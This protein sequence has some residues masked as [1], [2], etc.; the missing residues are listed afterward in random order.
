MRFKLAIAAVMLASLVGCGG[1]GGGSS[2]S[3]SNSASC[4]P[5]MAN[6]Q[7]CN[8]TLSLA[9]VNAAGR[10]T[11]Q[12]AHNDPGTLVVTLKTW[13]GKPVSGTLVTFDTSDDVTLEPSSGTAT[14]DAHGVARMGLPAGERGGSFVAGAAA[15]VAGSTLRS[16]VVYGV[17]LPT[18]SLSLVDKAGAPTSEVTPDNAGTLVAA[19]KYPNGAPVS[20]TIVTFGTNDEVTMVPASR[21]VLT[22]ARGEARV[23]LPAGNR[24][25]AF[26][27]QA[28]ADVRG[29]GLHQS[30]EYAVTFPVL[31]LSALAVQ[32]AT[33]SAGGNASLTVSV[34]RGGQPYT[35]PL[36]VSFTSPCVS[37]GK[38]TIGSPVTTQNG[39]ARA[40]YSDRGCGVA[41]T[42]TASAT[43]GEA[44][45]TAQ[46]TLN[47]LPAASGSLTFVSADTTNIALVGTGGAGRQ[48]F[49]TLRFRVFDTTGNPVSGKT[50]SFA[51]ANR[52]GAQTTT[53]GGLV[54]DPPSATS[55]PD[56][57]VTTLVKNGTIPTSVRVKAT[58]EVTPG[59]TI[60]TLSNV[61]VVSTG[62]PDQR[63][64]SLSTTTGNCEGWSVDQ[65]EC[66]IVTARLADHFGNPAP[67]GTAVNFTTEGGNIQAS[68]ITGTLLDSTTPQG[69]ST[70]SQQGPGSG[71]C[72]VKLRSANPRSGDGRVTVLAY[73]LGEEDFA[74]ANGNNR[75]DGCDDLSGP[76][77]QAKHDLKPDIYRDDDENLAYT[78]GEPCIRP[79]PAS[80][81]P[82]CN[83]P[84]DG[85]YS[86]VLRNPPQ[87]DAPLTVYVSQQLVQI[88]SGSE[89]NFEFL[90]NEFIC[91]VGGAMPVRFHARD[92]NGNPMPAGSTIRVS[93]VFGLITAPVVPTEI[94]VNNYVLSVGSPMPQPVYEFVVGCPTSLTGRL[95]VELTTPVSRTLTTATRP[96]NLP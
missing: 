76:E 72:S 66:S 4:T 56:G 81:N 3:G 11:T 84:G 7:A 95:I 86:G 78:A 23:G 82:L 22:D 9:L 75:C 52:D 42:I 70:N 45:V 33:L 63:H 14:T 50:V 34:T 59:R 77:F 88:F 58:V 47:V 74:D 61:L 19:L 39:V 48:E 35:P 41:D 40:S 16:T 69:E 13:D 32:P 60:T 57:S 29:A 80:S 24:S 87:P 96:I 65:D 94:K 17:N 2:G 67:D 43:L 55:G 30:R 79:D 8:A 26:L 93:A 25:G 1:G 46:G 36:Q 28:S 21:T 37:A 5:T 64:F 91:P 20:G 51:F 27:A 92:L 62:V 49:A 31:A 38:A 6:P 18:I 90:Q 68:C 15:T 85:R 71:S 10:P 54:L 73:A 83:T 44:T 89:A 12:L 53:T